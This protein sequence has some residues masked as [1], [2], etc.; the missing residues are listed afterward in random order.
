MIYQKPKDVTYTQMAI[1]IDEHAYDEN[2]SDEQNNLI[3]EYIYHIVEMLA[4]KAK[5]FNKYSYYDDF[6]IYVASAVYLRL[7]NPR[8][9]EYDKNG[10]PKLKRVKSILNYIKTILYP[11]KVDFEQEQY[12]QTF[13]KSDA[14]PFDSDIGI[15]YSFADS[16]IDSLDDITKVNFNICL[17]Q[18]CDTI[19]SYIYNLPFK[20][21]KVMILNL[22]ISC[23]LSFLSSITPKNSDLERIRNFKLEQHRNYNLQDLLENNFSEDDVILY[24]L[25]DIYRQYIFVL[26]KKIKHIIANDLSMILNDQV[27]SQ[28]AMK[29]I[30]INDIIDKGINQ[31]EE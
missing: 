21:D 22:Y 1:F 27:M 13:S 8:Q 20:N 28:S 29:S 14:I 15:R 7:K 24:H 16:L 31:G 26:T 3:F 19:K 6:A 5:F 18:I 25:D 10:N 2:S 11:K 12:D 30:L 23:L 9:F 4:Y 17:G